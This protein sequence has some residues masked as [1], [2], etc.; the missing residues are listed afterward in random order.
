MVVAFGSW[1]ARDS[2]EMGEL[3]SRQ[4]LAVALLHLSWSTASSPPARNRL[5]VLATVPTP[6]SN[7][8]AISTSRQ[9]AVRFNRM[10][11]RVWIRAAA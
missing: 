8:R 2:D 11:A 7:A 10:R 9:P 6:T 4:R 5:R 1:A 3:L